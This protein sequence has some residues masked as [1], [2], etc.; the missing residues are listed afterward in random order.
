MDPEEPIY[1]AAA[2]EQGDLN[3][4]IRSQNNPE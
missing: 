4:A 1:H 3:I 2:D